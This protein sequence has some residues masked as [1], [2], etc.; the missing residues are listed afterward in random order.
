VYV[1]FYPFSTSVT[2]DGEESCFT[3]ARTT[4]AWSSAA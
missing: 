1:I 2:F 3:M 4:T